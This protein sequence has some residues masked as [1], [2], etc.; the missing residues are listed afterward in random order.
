MG[1]DLI[2]N[3]ISHLSIDSSIDK[4]SQDNHN[5]IA[6]N[7]DEVSLSSERT[8]TGSESDDVHL[9]NKV[10]RI[11]AT[12]NNTH[13]AVNIGGGGCG[14]R[15][16]GGCGRGIRTRGVSQGA[17]GKGQGARGYGV[18]VNQTRMSGNG[19]SGARLPLSIWRKV[20][21]GGNVVLND[22]VFAETEGV[23]MRM[24]PNATCSDFFNLYF[25]QKFPELLVTETNRYAVQCFEN[26]DRTSYTSDWV[27]VKIDEI[28]VFTVLLTL[29]SVIHKPF[30]NLYWTTDALYHT[31][32]FS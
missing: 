5:N 15:T 9:A 2:N 31:P 6:G 32:I 14:I 10:S 17:R 11:D 18:Q 13:S 28:K 26:H 27:P 4:I 3:G 1:Q 20:Q 16:C 7:N 29:T 24:G 25:T 22:F 30:I 19:R 23:N 12:G 21:P 8:H